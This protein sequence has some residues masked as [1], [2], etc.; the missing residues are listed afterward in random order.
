MRCILE[1]INLLILLCVPVGSPDPTETS[2]QVRGPGG[3][4]INYC[5][6]SKQYAINFKIPLIPPFSKGESPFPPLWKRGVR[7]DSYVHMDY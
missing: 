5:Y 6:M 3:H 1:C 7:G 4:R 2:R